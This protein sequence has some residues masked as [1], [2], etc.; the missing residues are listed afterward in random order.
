M[1][2]RVAECVGNLES[3]LIEEARRS[4]R[5]SNTGEFHEF[6]LLRETT[7]VIV[8]VHALGKWS[9]SVSDIH[10]HEIVSL[11]QD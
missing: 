3:N 6:N 8:M 5:P 4:R 10:R 9:V 11:Y 2:I 1:G 7:E